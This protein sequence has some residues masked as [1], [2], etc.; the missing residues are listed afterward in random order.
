M[1]SSLARA[2]QTLV[3]SK[4]P[5]YLLEHDLKNPGDAYSVPFQYAHDTKHHYFDWLK[6]NPKQQ[7]AFN[8]VVGVSRAWNGE[9]FDYFPVEDKFSKDQTSSAN[10]LLID[11]GGGHGH[12][13]MAFKAKYPNLPGRFILQELPEVI[14]YIK[15]PAPGIEAMKYDF[16]MPQPVHGARAYYMRTVLHD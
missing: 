6:Q 9:W 3:L 8:S 15:D 1:L 11:I 5:E 13:L 4:L 14:D 10:A 12:D 2:E 7:A 16:F